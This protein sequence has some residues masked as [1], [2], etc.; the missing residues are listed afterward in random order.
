MLIFAA[1]TVDKP[2]ARWKDWVAFVRHIANFVKTGKIDPTLSAAKQKE[3]GKAAQIYY[4]E[5]ELS[6]HSAIVMLCLDLVG[7]L[8]DN[9]LLECIALSL[10]R[11]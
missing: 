10:P 2:A 7:L 3:I 5:C 1:L 11:N 6:T 8:V 9:I 4:I